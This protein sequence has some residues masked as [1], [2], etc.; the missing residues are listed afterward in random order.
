M[1]D[2]ENAVKPWSWAAAVHIGIDRRV[3]FHE[4]CYM[5]SSVGLLRT[6]SLGVYPGVPLLEAA[7]LTASGERAAALGVPPF[8]HMLRWLSA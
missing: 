7:G 3:V 2:L 5:V 8:P 4:G 1:H 6:F